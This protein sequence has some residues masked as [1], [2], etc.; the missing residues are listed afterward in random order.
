MHMQQ[1]E[2]RGNTVLFVQRCSWDNEFCSSIRFISFGA[3]PCDHT[4]TASI[5]ELLC[6]QLL[7]GHPHYLPQGAA[8]QSNLRLFASGIL[9]RL[10]RFGKWRKKIVWKRLYNVTACVIRGLELI[11]QAV[12]SSSVFLQACNPRRCQGH[13]QRQESPVQRRERRHFWLSYQLQRREIRNHDH[14]FCTPHLISIKKGK[15]SNCH[16]TIIFRNLLLWWVQT[17]ESQGYW[18]ADSVWISPAALLPV[19]SIPTCPNSSEH[20]GLCLL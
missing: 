1:L 10:W 3:A 8:W 7:L 18:L 20:G 9:D 16:I 2:S 5:P 13:Y 14:P 11:I 12:F 19:C 15:I 6:A 17:K 4:C